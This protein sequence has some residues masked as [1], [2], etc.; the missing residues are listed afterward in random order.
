MCLSLCSAEIWALGQSQTATFLL[1]PLLPQHILL[2]A[3]G[4]CCWICFGL[5][6]SFLIPCC[7]LFWAP[8]LPSPVLVLNKTYSWLAAL[9]KQMPAVT[10]H[11]NSA[12]CYQKVRSTLDARVILKTELTASKGQLAL[13]ISLISEIFWERSFVTSCPDNFKQLL[14]LWNFHILLFSLNP[15]LPLTLKSILYGLCFRQPWLLTFAW[16]LFLDWEFELSAAW[17]WPVGMA[18]ADSLAS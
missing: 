11:Q 16:H 2:V 1:I 13:R 6:A 17:Q 3:Y 8:V 10:S 5:L 12:F 4:L 9:N 14:T 18:L 15:F 7:P